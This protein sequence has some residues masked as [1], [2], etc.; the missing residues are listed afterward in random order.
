[1]K[2]V[3]VAALYELFKT[4]F[5]F[6]KNVYNTLNLKSKRGYSKVVYYLVRVRILI[7]LFGD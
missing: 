3:N 7:N 2:N 5:S 1:M 6:G 4:Y